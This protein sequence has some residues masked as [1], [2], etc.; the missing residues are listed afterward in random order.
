MDLKALSLISFPPLSQRRIITLAVYQC[1]AV[2]TV[3]HRYFCDTDHVRQITYIFFILCCLFSFQE[4][5]SANFVSWFLV[6]KNNEPQRLLIL[7][8]TRV[9]TMGTLWYNVY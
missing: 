9:A 4:R 8:V 3:A 5:A 1:I 2:F 6:P 7:K